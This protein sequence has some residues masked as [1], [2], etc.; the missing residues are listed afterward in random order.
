MRTI[1]LTNSQWG[2]LMKLMETPIYRQETPELEALRK[3]VFCAC[4]VATRRNSYHDD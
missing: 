2:M 1:T 4:Q 3:G